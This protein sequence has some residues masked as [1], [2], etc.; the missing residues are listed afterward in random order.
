MKV[1]RQTTAGRKRKRPQLWTGAVKF[2]D[3]L[4]S[5]NSRSRLKFRAGQAAAVD[6]SHQN[7]M[8]IVYNLLSLISNVS[9]CSRGKR[10]QPLFGPNRA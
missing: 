7:R 2:C 10:L 8:R 6:G 4:H 3:R 1:A 9:F 5:V